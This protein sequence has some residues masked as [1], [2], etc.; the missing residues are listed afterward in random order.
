MKC[1]SGSESK[2]QL[3]SVPHTAPCDTGGS[4]VHYTYS[5]QKY[6][7]AKY[8]Y[9]PGCVFNSQSALERHISPREHTRA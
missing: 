8:V 4:F 9:P 6:H 1:N 3:D 7:G 2:S 5:T